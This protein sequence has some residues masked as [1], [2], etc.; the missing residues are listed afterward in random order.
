VLAGAG[1]ALGIFAQKVL[2]PPSSKAFGFAAAA[3]QR[4]G[5]RRGKPV[6]QMTD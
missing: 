6:G 4:G 1:I 2:V 3:E 5:A